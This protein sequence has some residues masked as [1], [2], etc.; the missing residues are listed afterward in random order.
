VTRRVTARDGAAAVAMLDHEN[1]D[2]RRAVQE[3]T[4]TMTTKTCNGL[5]GIPAHEVPVSQFGTDKHT[6]DGL[7][8]YCK[9]CMKAYNDTRKSGATTPKKVR[10]P[11]PVPVVA[12]P[13]DTEVETEQGQA[14]LR[15][16]AEQ[17]QKARRAAAA[18]A[19]KR[20]RAA[21][22]ARAQEVAAALVARA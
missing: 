18:D 17:A 6:K 5:T 14:A 19:R 21:A 4:T 8:R 13:K 7:M 10:E 12:L 2:R 20:Q 9:G 11:K 15:D 3:G 22:K 1:R 16:A